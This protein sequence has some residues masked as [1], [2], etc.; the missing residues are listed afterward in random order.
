MPRK[1]SQLLPSSVARKQADAW[2]ELESQLSEIDRI[3]NGASRTAS[4]PD[5]AEDRL[6]PQVFAAKIIG[7]SAQTPVGG[8]NW[9]LY[10]WEEV[11]RSATGGTWATVSNGRK[12]TRSGTAYNSYETTIAN[13]GGNILTVTPTRL[14]YPTNAVV[15]MIIDPA[16]RAWFDNPNPV[17]ICP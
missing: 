16:G 14:A 12:S 6:V 7:S 1:L 13:N 17:Q 10:S 8:K 4:S 3:V 5:R 9:W 2:R 15:Q 11:E